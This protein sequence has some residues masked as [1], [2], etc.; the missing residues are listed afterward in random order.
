MTLNAL[1]FVLGS[2]PLIPLMLW[3]GTPL[4][5]RGDKRVMRPGILAGLF[6]FAVA[7][8]Q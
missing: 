6:L 7:G 1:R 4:W 3:R 2:L 5:P 8:A